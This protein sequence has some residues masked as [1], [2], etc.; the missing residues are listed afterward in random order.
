MRRPLI[1]AV[2]LLATA[3][4]AQAADRAVLLTNAGTLYTIES[5]VGDDFTSAGSARYLALT[6]QDGDVVR[7][8]IVPESET[9]NNWQPELAYDDES[10]TL[11]V[12]WLRSNNTILGM[13]E[14]LFCSYQNGK[15]NPSAS[16]DDLPYHFRFNLRVG[17]TRSVMRVEPD[18]TNRQIPGLTV[19]AAWWDES[20]SVGLA[21]YAMLVIE[22]GVVK[23]IIRRDL[24]NFI[25]QSFENQRSVPPDQESLLRHPFVFESAAKDTVD[26][27]FGD[28][29]TKSFY[30][31]KLKPVDN[32]RVRI[33]IGVREGAYPSPP[34]KLPSDTD[35]V[36]SISTAPNRLVI[37]FRS[38]GS[39]RYLIYDGRWSAAKS[40][41]L[42]DDVTAETAVAALRKLVNGD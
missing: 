7:K 4:A 16:V 39:L 2:L 25:G 28:V 38:G 18:G 14:L 35:R 20:G 21:R 10:G 13:N 1:I 15:W 3:F 24:I 41:S 11:F 36:E 33:P 6:I 19:H 22:K 23:D 31:V 17:V 29:P 42:S 9:G 8:T 32:T 40:I 30:R 34:T 12:F 5:R 26:I 27:V 37:H